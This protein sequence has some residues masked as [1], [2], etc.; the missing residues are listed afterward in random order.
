MLRAGDIVLKFRGDVV[1]LEPNVGHIYV[2]LDERRRTLR[3]VN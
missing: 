3:P 1:R 2:L